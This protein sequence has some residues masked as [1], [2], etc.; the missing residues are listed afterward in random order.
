MIKEKLKKSLYKCDYQISKQR[1]MKEQELLSKY[2]YTRVLN[3]NGITCALV[4]LYNPEIIGYIM[5]DL[6]KMQLSSIQ[7][8]HMYHITFMN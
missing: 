6:I 4:N 8:F 5:L 1:I 2:T 3:R 7:I